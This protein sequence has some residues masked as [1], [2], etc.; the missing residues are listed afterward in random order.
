MRWDVWAQDGWLSIAVA[1]NIRWCCFGAKRIYAGNL[2]EY[3][4]VVPSHAFLS[5]F[6]RGLIHVERLT[7]DVTIQTTST[8]IEIMNLDGAY[9]HVK[10]LDGSVTLTAVRNSHVYVQSING[11]INISNAPGSLIEANS[12]SGRITYDGDPGTGGDYRLSSYSGDV[13]VSIP[14]SALAEIQTDGQSG[15]N[16]NETATQTR[17]NSPFLR[18]GSLERAHFE[19]RSF[20][21]KIRLKRPPVH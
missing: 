13:D 1:M 4:V 14:E 20:M 16:P 12:T 21:G 15:Q 2:A 19:L 6:A 11:P 3:S 17:R 7:G 9:V 10:T 5:L 18:R 8:P